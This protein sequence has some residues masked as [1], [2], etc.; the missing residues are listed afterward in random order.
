MRVYHRKG[1]LSMAFRHYL[2]M[3][4][5]ELAACDTPPRDLAWMA[6]HFSPY[7]TGLSNI[8][9]SLPPESLL[10][11]NDRTPIHGHDPGKICD[12]LA[13]AVARLHCSG[14]LLDLQ[15][16]D[17]EETAALVEYLTDRLPCPLAVSQAYS[18]EACAVFLPPVPPDEAPDTY[19]HP[20]QGRSV[21]LETALTEQTLHVGENGTAIIPNQDFRGPGY[22]HRD[23]RLCCHYSISVEPDCAEFHI[24]RTAEDLADLLKQA[25]ALGVQ[26]C[27]G[28]YQELHRK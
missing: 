24:Y 7:S 14:V 5:A 26:A 3:T 2:A 15:I 20:W 18:T 13:Q 6:C 9:A 28:L 22:T 25:E 8:P 10:I 17:I 4:A 1:D 11:L 19:L 16:P 23:S 27:V 21:F 12:Q